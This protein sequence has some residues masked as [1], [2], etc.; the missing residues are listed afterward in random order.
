MS[1]VMMTGSEDPRV[2]RKS[3]DLSL[4][5]LPKPFQIRDLLTIIEEFVAAAKKRDVG[6]RDSE[7]EEYYP[8]IESFVSEITACYAVPSVPGRIEG[9]LVETVKRCLQNLSSVARYTERERVMALSGLLAAQVL[10]VS[11]PRTKSGLTLFEEYDRLMLERGRRTA[12]G[13]VRSHA[14]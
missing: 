11:L 8:P 14:S 6:R 10:G 3:R 12:F 9:R 7:D 5:F 4:T 1:I 2:E 13:P